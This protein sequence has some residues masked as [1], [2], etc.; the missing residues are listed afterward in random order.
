ML[1]PMNPVLRGVAGACLVAWSVYP[2]S[3]ASIPTQHFKGLGDYQ[4]L[5]PSNTLSGAGSPQWV[6][7]RRPVR[8]E[9]NIVVELGSRVVVQAATNVP[10]ARLV[11][12]QPLTLLREVAPNTWI[13]QAPDAPQAVS[14][15]AAL[16]ARPEVAAAYPVISK[17][18]E[19]QGRYAAYPSDSLFNYQWNLEHRNANGSSAGV[20]LN[21]REAWPISTGAGVTVA[22]ADTGIEFAHPELTAPTTGAP[23]CNFDVQ[24]N[25]AGP[26]SGTPNG[27]HGT[28]VSGLIAAT[29][30]S[31]RMVGVAP[32]VSLASWV[33]Y[34]TN[35]GSI[36]D[37]RLMDMYQFQS[38]TVSVQNHSWNHIGVGQ[39]AATLL[40]QI[41]ISNA[42]HQ[43]RSGKGVVMVR[44][45]GN[46]RLSGAN[47]NDDSYVN[48]PGTIGVA[49]VRLDGRT[50]SYS[51]PGACVLV[52][53]PS[54]DL[55]SGFQ[56]LFTTDLLTNRGVNQINFYPPYQDLSGYVFNND[57]F[58]GT[59]ASAPQVA[60]IAALILSANPQLTANDVQ[61]ILVA[62]SRQFDPADPDIQMN[63]AGFLFSH[64][65]GFGVPDAAEAVRLAKAWP[66]QP[67]LIREQFTIT[68]PAAIPDDGLRLLITGEGIPAELASIQNL[69]SVG[70]HADNPTPVLPLVWVGAGTNYSGISLTN[71]AALIE[72][73]S[74]TF[75]NA[76]NLAAQA[77][78]SFAVVYNFATNSDPNGAPGGDQLLPMGKTD[79]VPIPAIFIGHTAG[80]GLTNL[81]TT[82]VTARA[83]IRL[84]STNLTFTVPSTLR[85]QNAGLRVRTDHPLRGDLR[86]TLLSPSGTRSVL[87]R[88]NADTAAG[89]VN[90]TYWSRLHFGESG[91]GNWIA[92]I[93][94][95]AE[96]ATGNVLEA[97]L[98]LEGSLIVDTDHDGLDDAWE[99]S[100][101]NTLDQSQFDDPDKDGANNSREYLTG[102]NPAVAENLHPELDLSKWNNTNWR[103]SWPAS[104]YYNYEILTG[105]NINALQP[106]GTVP[107][108]FPQT[109]WFNP[110]G[111]LQFYR[112]RAIE[113]AK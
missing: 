54:G 87:Q 3:P 57:G 101:L 89:P 19:L 20:D 23:H 4:I 48:D 39:N 104:P 66:A 43:G 63:G 97:E 5:A 70:P 15:A 55:D 86:I 47:A 46:S 36:A 51:E 26:V 37:D 41:G 113:T 81:V 58:S 65:T 27:A 100:R 67:P 45:S 10:P 29:L 79:F 40:E 78:A 38:N 1:I 108:K 9:T 96:G 25:G 12:G 92:C 50:A 33:I 8:G 90:W 7:A 2:A 75:A 110:S 103:L 91:F 85:I 93:S 31:N 84:F 80:A 112:V 74:S 62:S 35:F 88:Y 94:D 83:R 44:S 77:G 16:S 109:E 22:V 98:I 71:K 18:T 107:G 49:A 105:T 34:R 111:P 21:V 68:G 32:G 69:P 24:T 72:R 82:N 42:I 28:E 73:S 13:F 53:A 11:K 95:E 106:V 99:T 61:Q 59:S 76:L 64:N 60:G 17:P 102:G 30:N 14:A 6:S 52:A 56:G